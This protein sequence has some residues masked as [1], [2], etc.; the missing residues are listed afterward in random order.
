MNFNEE[1]KQAAGAMTINIGT[2]I[3]ALNVSPKTLQIA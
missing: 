2:D 3:L 1:E